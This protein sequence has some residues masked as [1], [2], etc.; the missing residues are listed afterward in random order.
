MTKSTLL[1]QLYCIGEILCSLF[2]K[3]MELTTT[4]QTVD[5]KLYTH[6]FSNNQNKSY[7]KAITDH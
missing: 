7:T 1:L 3:E 6:H 4:E 2:T 5:V